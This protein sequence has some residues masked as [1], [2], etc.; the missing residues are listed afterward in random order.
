LP[1]IAGDLLSRLGFL[2][3]APITRDQWL[4][5]GRDNV[6]AKGMR[7]L[8]DFKIKP[9]PLAA[10]GAEWLGRFRPGGRFSK[11]GATPAVPG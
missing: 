1:D 8:A 7:G 3:G 5:L 10:V 9:T 2:P 11:R 6:V 4:M